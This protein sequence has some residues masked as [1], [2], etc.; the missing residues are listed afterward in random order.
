MKNY[1]KAISV[2]ASVAIAGA[3]IGALLTKTE[4]GKRVLTAMKKKKHGNGQESIET[5]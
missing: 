4:K 5:I 3:A 1:Q 2:I